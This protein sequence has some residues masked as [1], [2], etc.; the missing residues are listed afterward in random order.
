MK[1]TKME[2]ATFDNQLTVITTTTNNQVFITLSTY[3]G[4]TID[5]YPDGLKVVKYVEI[6]NGRV[7]EGETGDGMNGAKVSTIF[8]ALEYFVK[9]IKKFV[10][11]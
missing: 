3:N 6:S 2:I 11:D 7:N 8:E 9:E 10:R 5:G 1:T 4:A